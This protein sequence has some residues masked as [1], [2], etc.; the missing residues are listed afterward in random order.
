MN[1]RSAIQH[2]VDRFRSAPPA[3]AVP[4]DHAQE[5]ERLKAR[6]QQLAL[7]VQNGTVDPSEYDRA[8]QDIAAF[9]QAREREA[10]AEQERLERA[11]RDEQR[12]VEER[13]AAAVSAY[14]AIWS[15][16]PSQLDAVDKAASELQA[17]LA[18]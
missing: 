13:Q 5:L 9:F 7:D 3:T 16:L 2:V 12:Q 4:P 14:Q 1:M 18:D 6:Q 8:C 17:R 11:A 15:P 10:L